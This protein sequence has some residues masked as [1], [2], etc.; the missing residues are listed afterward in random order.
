MC[1]PVGVYEN[2][3]CIVLV[4]EEHCLSLAHI[5]GRTLELIGRCAA[6]GD[7]AW[8]QYKVTGWEANAKDQLKYRK[9]LQSTL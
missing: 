8:E 3:S 9:V 7:S 4:E 5:K 2:A 1:N 6:E